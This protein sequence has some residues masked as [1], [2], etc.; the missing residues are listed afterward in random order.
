MDTISSRKDQLMS[1]LQGDEH[2]KHE[3]YIGLMSYLQA[4]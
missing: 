3:A 2:E 4:Y 1:Q